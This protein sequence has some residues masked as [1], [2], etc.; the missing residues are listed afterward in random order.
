MST[1]H[2]EMPRCV[3]IA[4]RSPAFHASVL[5]TLSSAATVSRSCDAPVAGGAG[6]GGDG[7]G[8]CG[9]DGGGGGDGDGDGGGDGDMHSWAHDI[10]PQSETHSNVSMNFS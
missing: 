8:A 2:A 9:T 10:A 3:A 7:G 6:G 4:R 5:A 1:R